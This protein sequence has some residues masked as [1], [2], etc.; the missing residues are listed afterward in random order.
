MLRRLWRDTRGELDEKAVLVAL[1]V[2]A[3]AAGVSRLGTKVSQ[4]MT[5]LAN[6]L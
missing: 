3:A 1:F 6:A 5:N 2:L 4:A